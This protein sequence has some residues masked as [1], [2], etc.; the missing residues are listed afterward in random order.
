MLSY[1]NIWEA[2]S[3]LIK[4]LCVKYIIDKKRIS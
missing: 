2:G 3:V 4:H 1:K